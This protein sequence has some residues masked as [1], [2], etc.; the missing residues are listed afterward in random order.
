M[1]SE[2]LSTRILAEQSK[3]NL[4]ILEEEKFLMNNL[5]NLL[6]PQK[7]FLNYHST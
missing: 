2:Q 5:I 1:S 7:T 3:L 6:K 4:M